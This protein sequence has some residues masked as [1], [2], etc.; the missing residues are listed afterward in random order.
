[1][2][3]ANA[4][5]DADGAAARP[6]LLETELGSLAQFMQPDE[7]GL[8]FRRELSSAATNQAPAEHDKEGV[9]QTKV[10]SCLSG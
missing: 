6:P 2:L 4:D 5:D 1:M 10:A 3:S 8:I 7:E 9:K